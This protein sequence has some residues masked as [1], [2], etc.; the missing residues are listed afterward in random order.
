MNQQPVPITACDAITETVQILLSLTADEITAFAHQ[1]ASRNAGAA[2]AL[3][4]ALIDAVFLEHP[5]KYQ[6]ARFDLAG[7]YGLNPSAVLSDA[8]SADL[9]KAYSE[10]CAP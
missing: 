1:L 3:A 4:D 2:D 6:T 10:G 9:G 7:S 8:L 5:D